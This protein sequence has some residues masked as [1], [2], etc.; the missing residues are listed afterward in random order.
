MAEYVTVAT[1][2][3][4]PPGEFLA[5]EIDYVFMVLFNV[6]GEFYVLKDE[7]SHAQVTLSDG[8]FADG[9]VECPKHGARFDVRTGEPLTPPATKPVRRYPVR[10]VGD[11]IQVEVD[12]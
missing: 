10:V 6:A 4:V 11:E 5:F 8:E 3:E 1:V 7:C 2:D 9:V 12:W